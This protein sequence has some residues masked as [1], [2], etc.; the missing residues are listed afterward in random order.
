MPVVENP[1]GT[2]WLDVG[3]LFEVDAVRARLSELGVRATVLVADSTCATVVDEVRSSELYPKIVLRNGPEPGI[4]VQPAAIPEAHTLLLGVH[5]V[6][7]RRTGRQV[8]ILPRLIRGLAPHCYRG[9]IG[10]PV[11]PTD[12]PLSW[13]NDARLRHAR[14]LALRYDQP[15]QRTT[16]QISRLKHLLPDPLTVGSASADY[17]VSF[18]ECFDEATA[19]EAVRKAIDGSDLYLLDLE[20]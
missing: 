19:R 20:G 14:R 5:P 12:P 8:V 17:W 18:P 15:D 2:L 3:D 13:R 11:P 9:V 7:L 4:V 6:P 16:V 1:D 10:P